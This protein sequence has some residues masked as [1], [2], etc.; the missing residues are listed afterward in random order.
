MLARFLPQTV[1]FFELLTE[2]NEFLQ[3]MARGLLDVTENNYEAEASLKQINLLEED[4]DTLTRKITWHLSQTFITPIDR[5]DIHSINLAQ[6]RVADGLQ[7]LASR[8]YVCGFIYQRFPAQMIA[9][10]VKGMINDTAIML[11]QLARKKEISGSLRTLKSRK[12]DCEMLLAAGLA[13][14]QE[15]EITSFAMV[16]EIILWSQIYER[17]ER[18]VDL[19][20][21]LADTMEQVVLKYV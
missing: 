10:N 17:M 9:H 13:E 1:P 21:D 4:A 7:N 5:E 11:E 18:S 2:Q 6:E 12:A 15:V 19:V 16:K 14:L 8:I 20:S 3:K